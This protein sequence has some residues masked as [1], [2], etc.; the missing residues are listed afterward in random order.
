MYTPKEIFESVETALTLQT[1]LDD[2]ESSE[3]KPYYYGIYLWN[4]SHYACREIKGPP[5]RVIFI[6]HTL[7]SLFPEKDFDHY[8]TIVPMGYEDSEDVERK[9]EYMLSKFRDRDFEEIDENGY[10]GEDDD[11]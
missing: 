10:L 11:E 4:K 9:R 3:L 5:G 2:K 6:Y 7:G 1:L 8:I